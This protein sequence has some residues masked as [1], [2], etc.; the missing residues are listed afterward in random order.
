MNL[1][2]RT[3]LKVERQPQKKKKNTNH[4]RVLAVHYLKEKEG[5][6]RARRKEF[7]IRAVNW[8]AAAIIIMTS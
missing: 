3:Q 7:K 6:K 1:A 4:Y 5:M 2:T 8:L